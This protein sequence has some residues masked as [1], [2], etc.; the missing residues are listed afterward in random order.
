[1][2]YLCAIHLEKEKLVISALFAGSSVKM[3]VVNQ[4]FCFLNVIFSIGMLGNLIV[5]V[6]EK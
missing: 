5:T 6:L 4:Y 1:M 2:K 3:V